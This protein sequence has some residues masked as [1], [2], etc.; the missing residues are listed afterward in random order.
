MLNPRTPAIHAIPA[1]AVRIPTLRSAPDCNRPLT[2][3]LHLFPFPIRR[4]GHSS[5]RTVILYCPPVPKSIGTSRFVWGA[6][7]RNRSFISSNL[8]CTTSEIRFP[9]NRFVFFCSSNSSLFIH[10]TTLL[11][12][13]YR[14]QLAC[15]E[16]G[17]ISTGQLFSPFTPHR[18]SLH[19]GV[20]LLTASFW[21]LQVPGSHYTECLQMSM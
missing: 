17:K 16:P 10:F 12:D 3:S 1:P 21:I 9:N 6:S 2:R 18:H 20:T 19:R 11:P 8:I 14:S 5:P 13:R 15:Q 7:R 4:G